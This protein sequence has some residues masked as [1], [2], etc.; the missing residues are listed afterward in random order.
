MTV[1][2]ALHLQLVKVGL[3]YYYIHFW[4]ACE[5]QQGINKVFYSYRYIIILFFFVLLI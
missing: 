2:I 4:M 3:I 5:F 1:H